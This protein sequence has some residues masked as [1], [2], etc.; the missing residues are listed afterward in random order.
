MQKVCL[1][2]ELFAELYTFRCQNFL[3]LKNRHFCT[4]P[5]SL[6]LIQKNTFYFFIFWPSIELGYH[7]TKAT[8]VKGQMLLIFFALNFNRTTK[9]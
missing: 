3:N 7:K 9:F 5:I 4:I 1:K 6:Q 2:F 8:P